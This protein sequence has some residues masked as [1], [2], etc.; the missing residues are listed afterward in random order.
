MAAFLEQT[1]TLSTRALTDQAGKSAGKDTIGD[2]RSVTLGIRRLVAAR[3]L[4]LVTALGGRLLDGHI[5]GDRELDVAVALVAQAVAG[6]LVVS[7]RG[8]GCNR[9]SEGNDS[10]G[11]GELHCD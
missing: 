4:R 2:G 5:V 7:D 10:G 3:Q 9:G 11:D 6:G 8:E 1:K